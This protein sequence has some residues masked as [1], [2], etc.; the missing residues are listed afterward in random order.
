M[1]EMSRPT[2]NRSLDEAQSRL[3]YSEEQKN[4]LLLPG[5]EPR[6]HY[7]PAHIAGTKL[8]VKNKQSLQELKF[9][10]IS[11]CHGINSVF[12]YHNTTTWYP[13][14]YCSQYGYWEA[15]L[16]CTRWR[17]WLR[18]CTTNRKVA[19]SIPGGVIGIFHWYNPSGRT[20]ALGLTQPL[21]E[22]STKNIFWGVKASSA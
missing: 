3:N 11:I 8:Y 15:D 16:W 2:H 17:S 18:N 19:G 5:F 14:E 12:N 13:P 9:E 20:V 22:M 4:L 21:T 6:F 7:L 1:K 10:F